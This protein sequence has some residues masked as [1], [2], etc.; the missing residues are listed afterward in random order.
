M[1]SQIF[2]AFSQCNELKPWSYS[3]FKIEESPWNIIGNTELPRCRLP[4][5]GHACVNPPPMILEGLTILSSPKEIFSPVYRRY[6]GLSEHSDTTTKA[7][8]HFFSGH[9]FSLSALY[10]IPLN[11]CSTMKST[12][13]K[14]QPCKMPCWPKHWLCRA[15]NMQ[16]CLLAQGS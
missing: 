5:S 4:D 7:G 15:D 12:G 9:W 14:A 10:A 11:V 6:Q 13:M 1:R 16:L 2:T 3:T 8:E